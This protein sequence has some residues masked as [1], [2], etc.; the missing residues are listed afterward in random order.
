MGEVWNEKAGEG[1]QRVKMNVFKELILSVYKYESYRDFLKNK[2]R[3]AF[4]AGIVLMVIYFSLTMIFPF[5]R[6]QV[7]TGGFA[8]IIEDFIPD[9]DLSGGKLW[10]ERPIEYESGGIYLNINTYPDNSFYDV[11]EIGEYISDYYQVLLVDSEKVITKNQGEILGEYFSDLNIEF[12]RDRLQQLVPQAYL[13]A[14]AFMVLAFIFMTTMF[15]FGVL[16]VALL[17]MIVASVMNYRLTFGQLYQM[18]IYTRTLPL[19]TKALL[20][21]LPFPM[22]MFEIINFGLSVLYI[23]FAIRKMKELD[24]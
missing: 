8:R 1:D 10:V 15:F 9:F 22:P 4:L 19:M 5:I 2:R 12:N 21:F 14:A 6:F 17:G 20:S 18:G 24:E 3:K 13:I 16:I 23:V 7:H 11:D